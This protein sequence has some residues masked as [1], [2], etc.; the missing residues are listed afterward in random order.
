[1]RVITLPGVVDSLDQLTR[2]VT[3]VASDAR[4]A[5]EARNRLRLAAEEIFTNIVLHGYA[6]APRE[7]DPRPCA[8]D[9]VVTVESEVRDGRVRL[10]FKDHAAAFDPTTIPDPADLAQPLS[11][12]GIG[13]LGV[14][15]V[16]LTMDEF[17]YQRLDG[18]NVLTIALAATAPSRFTQQM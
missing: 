15:L 7:P 10:R 2:F 4:M 14:Y 8:D 11:E 18:E 5:S 1:M 12:R 9:Q 17:S 16:R 3:E 13:G 6:D